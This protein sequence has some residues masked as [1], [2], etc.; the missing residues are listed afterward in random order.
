L[1]VPSSHPPAAMRRPMCSP[2]C[3]YRSISA[4]LTAATARARAASISR[5]ISSKSDWAG[6]VTP[7]AAGRERLLLGFTL[8]HPTSGNVGD[9]LPPSRRRDQPGE[10]T[11]NRRIQSSPVIGRK[12]PRE[13]DSSVRP[14]EA[15]PN[16]GLPL[17]GLPIA[18][19]PLPSQRMILSPGRYDRFP[20]LGP[21]P[22]TAGNRHEPP[23]L[24]TGTRP[25]TTGSDL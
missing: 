13:F 8:C 7:L 21:I 16:P 4:V 17:Y 19:T 6:V 25:S 10:A 18:N 12:W 9:R 14:G 20:T 23:P 22:D 3:Q 24:S 15:G 1:T 5:R 11:E 2:I